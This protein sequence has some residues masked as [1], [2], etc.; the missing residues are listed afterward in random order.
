MSSIEY[1]KP[2]YPVIVSDRLDNINKQLKDL[3]SVLDKETLQKLKDGEYDI[4][5]KEYTDMNTY[6]TTMNALYGNN[7][8]S[9]F[10]SI[11]NSIM[12]NSKNE[13]VSAK[14]FVESMKE[15]GLSN[16]SAVKL[17]SALKTYSITSSLLGK[18]NS[19]I[20]AKI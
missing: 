8:A 5:L 6:K 1:I 11:L 2:D 3:P 4:T 16:T 14:K 12:G 20:S 9:K 17:Y 15:K 13:A 19:F 7:S 18:N 10:P